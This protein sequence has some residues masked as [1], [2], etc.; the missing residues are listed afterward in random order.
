MKKLITEIEYLSTRDD[1]SVIAIDGRCCS[2]KTTFAQKLKSLF[3]CTVI[4]I[5]DFFLPKHIQNKKPPGEIAGNIDKERF[6][7]EVIQPLTKN[8]SITYHRYDCALD[9]F[10][11]KVHVL[12]TKLIVI[13]GVYSLYPEFSSIYDYSIFMDVNQDVQLNRLLKREGKE[14]TKIFVA[15]WLPREERYYQTYS[16]HLSCDYY[17]DTSNLKG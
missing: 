14:K 17:L 4:Q 2:G 10:T 3:N 7:Y 1:R 12:P 5:D 6:I 9:V 8:K 16:P 11:E 15:K 13:E